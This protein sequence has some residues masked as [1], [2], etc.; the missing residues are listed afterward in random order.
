M[1]K[2]EVCCG[3]YFDAKQAWYGGADRIELNSALHLGGLTPSIGALKLC[4]ENLDIPI[5]CMVRPR[6]SGFMYRVDEVEEIFKSARE[7]LENGADGIAFGFLNRDHTINEEL[8]IR[9]AALCHIHGKQ[10]V[11][12]RAFDC[13]RNPFSA[14]EILT[15]AHVDRLLTSGL[16]ENCM[17][18]STLIKELQRVYG[19]RIEILPGC[20]VNEDNI[21]TLIQ[22]TG[23]DQVHSSCKGYLKDDTTHGSK[24]S[25]AY[26]GDKRFEVV[27]ED[28]VREMKK[29]IEEL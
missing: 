15:N 22:T 17:E 28:R 23:V 19:S 6:P 7:L 1:V 26:L 14:M 2:L 3:S 13:V 11:F 25:F 20:G 29:L 18:G 8:T 9:M 5:I 24:V 12:H 4:K 27:D 10:A 16:E 21:Q